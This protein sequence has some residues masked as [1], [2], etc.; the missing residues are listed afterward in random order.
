MP[1]PAAVPDA[2][3]GKVFRGSLVV[4]LGLLTRAQLRSPVW[5]RVRQDI[6]AEARLVVD[7]GLMVSAAA[8]VLPQGGLIAG[9]S[10]A[11]LYGAKQ[12]TAEDPVDAL[13]PSGLS[14]WAPAGISAHAEASPPAD[15]ATLGK[16]RVTTCARTCIDIARWHDTLVAVP[17]ID[18]LLSAR[19]VRVF[20]LQT[21]LGTAEDPR[22]AQQTLAMCDGRAESPPESVLRVRLILAGLPAP[23]PQYEVMQG[24]RF[25]ARVDL[26]WP[27]RK[28][29]VEYDGAWHG[30]PGQ[31]GK[32]RR[33]LNALIKAGWTVI[34]V[35]AAD[36]HRLSGVID[37]L[38]A[39]L[40]P[41]R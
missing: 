14:R 40:P 21:Q 28:V 16:C 35:T 7:H 1:Y 9:R 36:L 27:E 12:A 17:I 20:E 30:A 32:D 25:I 10:A 6:Y 31:L 8:L 33:R 38:R 19:L 13:V 23:V 11:W 39:L 4:R 3:H 15:A 2:L 34:H 37:Q 41:T 24:A 5:C 18:A 22:Q 26:G 29:A